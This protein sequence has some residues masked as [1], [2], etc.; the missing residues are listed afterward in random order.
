MSSCDLMMYIHL[1][2]FVSDI[3]RDFTLAAHKSTELQ[4]CQRQFVQALVDASSDENDSKTPTIATVRTYASTMLTFHVKATV[5]SPLCKDASVM[6]WLLHPNANIVE[7]VLQG[8]GAAACDDLA[9]WLRNT[10]ADFWSAARLWYLL[11]MTSAS[12]AE[13]K[14]GYL[15]KGVAVLQCTTQLFSLV[16]CML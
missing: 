15:R 3:V 8:V 16:A 7:Q 14:G 12:S 1:I 4:Q 5:I 2:L 11:A 9:M 6:S 13:S 10:K